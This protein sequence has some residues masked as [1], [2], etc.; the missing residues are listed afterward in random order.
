M[1]QHIEPELVAI[2]PPRRLRWKSNTKW[3]FGALGAV[4]VIGIGLLFYFGWRNYDT[5]DA[6][7]A[8][9]VVAQG[10][11]YDKHRT[12]GQNT[13]FYL[14]YRFTADSGPVEGA[15]YVSEDIYEQAKKGDALPV[16]YLPQTQGRIYQEG[17]VTPAQQESATSVFVLVGIA[18]SVLL[19]VVLRILT[20]RN[21]DQRWFLKYGMPVSAILHPA[22]SDEKQS[23]YYLNYQYTVDN[24]LY[25]GSGI[26]NQ[27][28]YIAV[29]QNPE[30]CT[31]V[32]Y[33][34]SQPSRG[35]LYCMASESYA[36]A[37]SGKSV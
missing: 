20:T 6:L 10:T 34:A 1:T 25:F 9:G 17:G 27:K 2:K 28:T 26:V 15:S 7:M 35:M 13:S 11:V 29:V 12:E 3:L 37:T 21:Q 14:D 30:S 4:W 23:G 5:W 18:V 24:Q 36:V 19:A 16:T 22:G 33:D 31:T 32:L 8:R